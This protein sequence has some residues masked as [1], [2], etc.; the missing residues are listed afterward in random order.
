MFLALKEIKH[1]K[2]R[3]GLVISMV[4]LISYLIF[5]LTSLAQG[6]SS[7]NTAAIDTWNINQVILN[8]DSNVNMRQSFLTTQQVNDL[9]QGKDDALIGQAAVVTKHQDLPQVSATFIGLKPDQFIYQDM[10]VIKGHKPLKDNQLIVD[11]SFETKGY[12]LGQWIKLNSLNQKYQ[13]VGFVKNAKINISPIAYGKL[14]AW[15]TISNLNPNFEA[16]ALV[17]KSNHYKVTD[18][19]LKAYSVSDFISN[20]P[21]YTAQNMT[22]EFMIGFLMII[23]LIVIAIFLYIITNQKLPNYAVL[24][25]Q[26]IPA[27]TLVINT[28][29]QSLILVIS[30]ILIAAIL[31][32]ITSLV[33]P[34]AVPMTFNLPVLSAVAGGLVLTSIIGAILPVRTIMKID[35]VKVIG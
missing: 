25:A 7:Q 21:G 3:Y 6:L 2:L 18:N 31:T 22:F 27:K 33:I 5:I 4:V 16:N 11:S 23:S 10:K 35:P 8:K 26:G 9:H 20:L 24:R 19:D 30:G 32:W 17:T 28:I 15:K 1:E 12:K 13:I 29:S 34:A 14:S